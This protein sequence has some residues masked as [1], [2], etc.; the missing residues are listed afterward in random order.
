MADGNK[1]GVDVYMSIKLVYRNEGTV[2]EQE[3]EKTLPEKVLLNSQSVLIKQ[4]EEAYEKLTALNDQAQ[5]IHQDAQIW[6]QQLA[7]VQ[8]ALGVVGSEIEARGAKKGE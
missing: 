3:R 8:F 1:L 2:E 4:I 6:M 5:K 7:E